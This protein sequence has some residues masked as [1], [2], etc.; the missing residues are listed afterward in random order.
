MWPFLERKK[1]RHRI[2][3][4][5]SNRE[6]ELNRVKCTVTNGKTVAVRHTLVLHN[7]RKIVIARDYAVQ[8][9]SSKI[10]AGQRNVICWNAWK[11]PPAKNSSMPCRVDLH[12]LS[13][14]RIHTERKREHLHYMKMSSKW[15]L[16]SFHQWI[17]RTWLS[18]AFGRLLRVFIEKLRLF[19]T[20]YPFYVDLIKIQL[21][22]HS[23]THFEDGKCVH[24]WFHLHCK[25]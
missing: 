10:M 11:W 7:N 13:L 8:T 3:F 18:L 5:N 14:N 20:N 21:K 22:I 1:H 15:T 4:S 24:W 2:N 9:Q 12:D 6:I 17:H 19:R 25:C 16:K 23:D